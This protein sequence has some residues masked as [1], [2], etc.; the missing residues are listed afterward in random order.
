M[1]K[2]KALEE[3][4]LSQKPHFDDHDSFMA[5]VTK[6]LDAVE[7]IHQ[8]QEATIRRYSF[9]ARRRAALCIPSADRFPSL[10]CRIFPP[11]SCHSP[12]LGDDL[13]YD[14]YNQ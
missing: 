14:E 12:R 1:T 6:R 11:N 3:L 13:W 4:F 2:D 5:T 8:H 10:A 9:H 7:Y